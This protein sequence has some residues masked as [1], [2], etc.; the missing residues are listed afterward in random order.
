LG[1]A[2]IAILYYNDMSSDIS[3]VDLDEI[4]KIP[5]IIAALVIKKDG[6]KCRAYIK[7]GRHG[8]I[9]LAGDIAEKLC[10]IYIYPPGEGIKS[11]LRR[12]AEGVKRVLE[13]LT[14]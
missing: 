6:N 1:Q 12:S 4:E 5:N 10:G 3:K 13:V 2:T 9:E 11:M 8:P 14:N 7:S